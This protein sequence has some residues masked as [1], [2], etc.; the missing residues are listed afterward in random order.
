[1]AFL[2]HANGLAS[3]KDWLFRLPKKHSPIGPAAPRSSFRSNQLFSKLLHWY[4][5]SMTL[6]TVENFLQKNVAVL[7]FIQNACY[8]LKVILVAFA[9]KLHNG[10]FGSFTSVE[11]VIRA[12]GSNCSAGSRATLV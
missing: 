6:H 3:L 9:Y 11:I 5:R 2:P 4:K 7:L 8:L 12:Y 10:S 1:M